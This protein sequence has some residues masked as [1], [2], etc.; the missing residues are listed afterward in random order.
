MFL[1]YLCP[2][3]ECLLLELLSRKEFIFFQKSLPVSHIMNA[4]DNRN[5]DKEAMDKGE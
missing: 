3:K 4:N 5:P 1:F 2:F